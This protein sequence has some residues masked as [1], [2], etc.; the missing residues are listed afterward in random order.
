MFATLGS[1]FQNVI[2]EP[3]APDVLVRDTTVKVLE[4]IRGNPEI[5]A[6]NTEHITDIV[7]QDLLEHFNFERM[8]RLAMG[9]NWR[10]VS[11]AQKPI[12]VEEFKSLLVRTYSSALSV[13]RDQEIVTKPLELPGDAL[14]ATV[15]TTVTDPGKKPISINYRMMLEQDEWKV[16]DVIVE[17]VSLVISY[18]STFDST[19]EASGIDGLIQALKDKNEG[20]T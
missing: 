18:R 16:F 19:I 10:I 7:A 8:T 1:L 2:A 20:T 17:G 14:K 3:I 5:G 4:V 9:K 6:G 12:L 11:D 15:E 13:Y